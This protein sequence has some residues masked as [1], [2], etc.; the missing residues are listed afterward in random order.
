MGLADSFHTH[1][2]LEMDVGGSW[3]QL[4][5]PVYTGC[6]SVFIVGEEYYMP[7]IQYNS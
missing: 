5:C 4:P 1:A 2:F 6:V 3:E 7:Q